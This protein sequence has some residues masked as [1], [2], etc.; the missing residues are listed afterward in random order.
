MRSF[1]EGLRRQRTLWIFS[2]LPLL[3]TWQH[4]GRT[5]LANCLR[6]QRT[7][8]N[9]SAHEGRSFSCLCCQRS[10]DS[11]KVA[12]S[13]PGRPGP[14]TAHCANGREF[15][16]RAWCTLRRFIRIRTFTLDN[17]LAAIRALGPVKI[18]RPT[19]LL[20]VPTLLLFFR[21]PPFFAD[22]YLLLIKIKA[23]KNARSHFFLA[24]YT[25]TRVCLYHPATRMWLY[26]KPRVLDT[27]T[28]LLFAIFW[29]KIAI[30]NEII[31]IMV[32][33]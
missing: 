33:I 13:C 28:L 32:M 30:Y 19:N 1:V 12:V 3:P 6:C 7:F 9:D 11:T 17:A 29:R 26:L 5:F 23:F 22:L 25:T 4:E 20:L 10:N 24:V 8:P 16:S 21:P 18:I 15:N 31:R 27:A 14:G 2:F